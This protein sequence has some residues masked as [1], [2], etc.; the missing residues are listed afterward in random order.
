MRLKPEFVWFC[1]YRIPAPCDLKR[2]NSVCM[3]ISM[4][5]VVG[6]STA[7]SIFISVFSAMLYKPQKR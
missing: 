3:Y 5:T 6:A 4:K 1:Y 7:L 2:L